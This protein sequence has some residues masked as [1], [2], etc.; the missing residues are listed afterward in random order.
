MCFNSAENWVRP[1]CELRD[2]LLCPQAKRSAATR[3][4]QGVAGGG[5]E[6]KR[7]DDGTG[8]AGS[9]ETRRRRASG[10]TG[11]NGAEDGRQSKGRSTSGG[12]AQRQ[13]GTAQTR[14]TPR[15]QGVAEAEQGPKQSS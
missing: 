13:G 11:S 10:G 1:A 15:G 6:R 4:N 5:S 7:K 12:V 14:A 3:R 8:D 9:D 2:A